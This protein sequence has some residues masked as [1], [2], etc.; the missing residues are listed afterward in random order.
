L[1]LA[2]SLGTAVALWDR[3]LAAFAARFHVVRF[4]MRGHGASSV[5]SERVDVE[6]LARDVIA[7]LDSRRIARAHF[8]GLSL[9]GMVG[10]WLGA[11]APE[12]LNR[13]VLCNTAAVIGPR[14]AWDERIR[15]V[16][17]GGTGAI[18]STVLGRW[19]T[20]AFQERAP[21]VVDYAKRML[22]ATNPK[23][24]VAAC[25]AVRDMDLREAAQHVRVPTLIVAGAEDRV[26]PPADGRWLAE[27]IAAARYAELPAAHLS[28]IEAAELFDASVLRFLSNEEN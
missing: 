23:G 19:F 26:T 20:P 11:H 27:R 14:S 21:E 22:L 10:L 24:Y 15:A 16:E 18:A 8:C 6:R 25:E 12:R 13:L 4:D 9:G 3:Q 7:L 1:V 5:S 28:N 2:N 17:N